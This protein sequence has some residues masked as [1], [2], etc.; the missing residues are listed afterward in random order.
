MLIGYARISKADG[1]QVLDL[2]RDALRAAGVRPEHMYEDKA[3]GKHDDRP[4]LAA[5]L[6][7]WRQGDTLLVWQLD[8]L[9]RSLQH[10]IDTRRTSP[11]AAS[12]ARS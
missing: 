11:H 3:S 9:G 4:A 5:C 8:R 2:Q 12:G 6:K 10:L 7:A 1:S